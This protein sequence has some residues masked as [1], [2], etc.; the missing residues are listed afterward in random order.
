M[1]L[2]GLAVTVGLVAGLG[3]SFLLFAQSVV[4]IRAPEEA[5][6]DGIVVLTGGQDRIERAVGL[7]QEERARRL[8]ISG[9]YP[10]TTDRQIVER[11]SGDL[12]LFRCCVDLDRKALN[13]VGNAVET[14]AWAR[15]H[16]FSS[17]LLVTSAYH[18]PRAA[19]ELKAVMPELELV[20]YPVFAED[21]MLS[22][23]YRR[24]QTIRLLL[25]EFVKYTLAR[26][27]I[28]TI[29]LPAAE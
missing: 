6:A 3:I 14:A 4:S 18:L 24:P 13:T 16:G 17:L 15:T 19:L 25:R 2:A 22:S 10:A 28:G 8:L 20:P 23:W 1:L 26:L 21:L 29:G 9:V 7:L 27:R 5:S 12:P 11:T